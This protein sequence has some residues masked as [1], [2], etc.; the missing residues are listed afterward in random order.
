MEVFVNKN[1]KK[2]LGVI[3]AKHSLERNSRHRDQFS[4]E[5]ITLNDYP[6]LIRRQGQKY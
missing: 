1:H 3:V 5:I 4:V 6:H 2:I